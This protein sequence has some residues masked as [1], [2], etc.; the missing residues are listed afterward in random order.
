MGQNALCSSTLSGA[1]VARL[2][3]VAVTFPPRAAAAVIAL[4]I[5]SGVVAWS[6][7]EVASAPEAVGAQGLV[8]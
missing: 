8:C 3:I 4:A 2:A 6:G 7:R 5:H 1:L